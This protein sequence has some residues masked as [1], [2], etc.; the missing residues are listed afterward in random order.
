MIFKKL[1]TINTFCIIHLRW[2]SKDWGTRSYSDKT[3]TLKYHKNPASTEQCFL[4]LGCQT[5]SN[6]ALNDNKMFLTGGSMLSS[7][8]QLLCHNSTAEKDVTKCQALYVSQTA[9]QKQKLKSHWQHIKHSSKFKFNSV[10]QQSA[11]SKA[12]RLSTC[13]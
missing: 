1:F 3:H 2:R 8:I 12:V 11:F 6:K 4:Q 9:H 13:K 5:D 10:S 7:A